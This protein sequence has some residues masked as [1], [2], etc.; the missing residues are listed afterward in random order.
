VSDTVTVTLTNEERDQLVRGLVTLQARDPDAFGKLSLLG[1]LLPKLAL[2]GKG[3]HITIGVHG[4]RVQWVLGNPFP[5][6]VC[7]YDGDD[8]ELPAVDERDQRCE[9]W[10][11][12]IDDEWGKAAWRELPE[13]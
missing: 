11:E 8:D 6:R 4:G 12:P 10:F 9:M 2:A 1:E 13:D 3:P 7:D 5:V